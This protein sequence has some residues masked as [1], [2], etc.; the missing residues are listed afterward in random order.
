MTGGSQ[1]KWIWVEQWNDYGPVQIRNLGSAFLVSYPDQDNPGYQ[2][3]KL[4]D[5]IFPTA[6]SNAQAYAAEKRRGE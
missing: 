1:T 6:W 4:F 2:R 5:K 3:E